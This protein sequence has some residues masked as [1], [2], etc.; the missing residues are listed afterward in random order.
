MA[1]FSAIYTSTNKHISYYLISVRKLHG[2]YPERLFKVKILQI[3]NESQVEIHYYIDDHD[4]F[5]FL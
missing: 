5:N 3:K 1:T 2:F 4:Y